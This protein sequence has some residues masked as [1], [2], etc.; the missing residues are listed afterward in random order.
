MLLE[1]PMKKTQTLKITLTLL[2]S[3][4]LAA[5]SQNPNTPLTSAPGFQGQG[6]YQPGI[7]PNNGMFPNRGIFPQTGINPVVNAPGIVT[8]NPTLMAPMMNPYISYCALQRNAIAANL[9]LR[10]NWNLNFNQ[11]RNLY[12]P[13]RA[14]PTCA[15]LR[16][17]VDTPTNCAC[18]KA[19]CNCPQVI[20]NLSQVPVYRQRASTQRTRVLR[21][22]RAHTHR[23]LSDRTRNDRTDRDDDASSDDS[24]CKT[25]RITCKTIRKRV[26][27]NTTPTRTR[28]SDAQPTEGSPDGRFKIALNGKDAEALYLRLA[29]STTSDQKN[30]NRSTRTGKNYTCFEDKNG[31]GRKNLEYGCFFYFEEATGKAF[32]WSNANSRVADP[33]IGV[34]KS[35]YTGDQVV[36][37]GE[38]G[39]S[40]QLPEGRYTLPSDLSQDLYAVLN[41]KLKE[42]TTVYSDGSNAKVVKGDGVACYQLIDVITNTPYRCEILL[43]S[44]TGEILAPRY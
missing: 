33:V 15:I 30:P 32:A 11:N 1:N 18:V 22:R 8:T 25:Y 21:T 7:F 36:I 29:R 3:F 17:P 35:A 34:N 2:V 40:L 14:S 41:L 44:N 39:S 20:Q 19:P 5:C 43:N 12:I 24:D 27:R 42:E 38:T 9:Q 28:T 26:A 37:G 4:G 23:T 10:F 13:S 31:R 6:V 16:Y